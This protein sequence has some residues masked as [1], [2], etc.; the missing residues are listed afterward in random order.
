MTRWWK[1]PATCVPGSANPARRGLPSKYFYDEVGSAL[2]EAICTLPEYGLTRACLRLLQ[3][4]A[5]EIAGWLR[6]PLVVAEL[7]SGSGKKTRWILQALGR[8]QPVTYCPIDISPA[9]LQMCTRE[10]ADL[11]A[12]A[13]TGFQEPYLD[14][15]RDVAARRKA[16]EQL[17]VLFLGSNIGNFDRPTGLGFLCEVRRLLYPGDGLLLATDLVKPVRQLISAYD[18]PIGVTAAF[19]LNLLARFNRELDADFDLSCFRHLAR[20]NQRERQIEMHLRSTQRQTVRI[21]KANFSVSFE[22][23]ETIWTESSYKYTIG[24]V[25][26]MAGQTGFRPV[27]RWIDREWPYAENLWLAV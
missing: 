12:V 16:E 23:D 14:G 7:G 11:D 26:R 20:Y 15:L 8:R 10:L 3:R 18:D 1:W 25:T 19:N 27:A 2:F 9:A 13:V 21:R 22:A 6:P 5:A 24:E 17:F 4:H